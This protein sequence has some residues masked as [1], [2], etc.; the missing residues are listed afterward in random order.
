MNKKLI[1]ILVIAIIAVLILL[2]QVVFADVTMQQ[3]VNYSVLKSKTVWFNISGTANSTAGNYTYVLRIGYSNGTNVANKTMLNDSA[4][5][6]FNQTVLEIDSG[7]GLYH[8]WTI[9]ENGT[10]AGFGYFKVDSTIPTFNSAP[11]YALGNKSTGGNYLN[12][13]VNISDINP[14]GCKASLYWGDSTITNASSEVSYNASAQNDFW[15]VNVTPS[16]ITKDGYA[17]VV[18]TAK[19]QA[20]N[21]NITPTNGTYIFYRLKAGWNVITGYENKTLTQIAAEF[22]NVTYVSVWDNINK[23]FATFTTG[24]STNANI[25]A[26]FSSNHSSGAVFVYVNADVVSMRRYYAVPTAWQNITLFSNN[27]TNTPWNLIGVIKQLTNLNSTIM[28]NNCTNSSGSTAYGPN[29]ANITWISFW[30]STEN[31]FCSFYRNR[32]AT[33]CSLT[34]DLYNLTR[35][36]ALWLAVQSGVNITLMRGSW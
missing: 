22:T 26:N 17:E 7:F 27:T 28:R 1:V 5:H 30:S 24:G 18:V 21:E 6:F 4:T 15:F 11:G 23:A 19:D 14:S 2:S 36:D 13:S 16:D 25:G 8:N 9:Y 10:A 3:P 12:V 34:S 35:G 32:L 31:K 29:C 33:S 20:G